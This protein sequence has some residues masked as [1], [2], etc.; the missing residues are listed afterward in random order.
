MSYPRILVVNALTL[1]LTCLLFCHCDSGQA[2]FGSVW[3]F[4][5][6]DG[7]NDMHLRALSYDLGIIELVV[8]LIICW[9]VICYKK[10]VDQIRGYP[11]LTCLIAITLV[12]I[13]FMFADDWVR[14]TAFKSDL[15]RSKRFKLTRVL[16]LLA[17]CWCYFSGNNLFKNLL[18]VYFFD[19]QH[20]LFHLIFEA[21]WKKTHFVSGLDLIDLN[22]D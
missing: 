18:L 14:W 3:S 11:K 15:A 7:F 8:I 1:F 22:L 16:W 4:F 20:Y 13:W 10:R 6:Y 19:W 12:L 2:E 9:F 21:T 17:W 5:I